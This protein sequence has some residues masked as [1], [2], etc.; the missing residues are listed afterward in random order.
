M[1]LT[2]FPERHRALVKLTPPDSS[3]QGLAAVLGGLGASYSTL[4]TAQPAEI[5]LTVARS[6][7]VLRAVAA[8]LNLINGKTPRDE[9]GRTLVKLD[10][11]IEITAL[12]GG[13]LQIEMK[14]RDPDAALAAV[15]A[16]AT[17]L[18]QRLSDLSKRQVAYKREILD[19]RLAEAERGVQQAQTQ[20]TAFRR[21]NALPAPQ[22]QLSQAV[23]TLNTLEGS[24]QA[25]EAELATLQRFAGPENYQVK[26]LQTEIA[27]TRRQLAEERSRQQSSG[28]G[29]S[30]A[31]LVEINTRYGDLLRNLSFAQSLYQS[32]IRYLEGSA[33]EELTAQYSLERL[34]S[35]HLDPARQYNAIPLA[36]LILVLLLATAAELYMV[37]P[38]V[39]GVNDPMGQRRSDP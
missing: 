38:P 20:L 39:L 7:D 34:E 28:S 32:Y 5:D 30:A 24:L 35:T 4:L 11:K 9:V 3:A 12:R 18:R 23:V 6:W 13:I 1:L 8:R 21:V 31:N 15:D 19:Q 25:K 14:D 2:L 29:A 16:F 10:R 37:A 26:R 22:E 33:V 36:L 27:V 17:V